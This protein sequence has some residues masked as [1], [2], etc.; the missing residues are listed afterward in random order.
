[1]TQVTQAEDCAAIEEGGKSDLEIAAYLHAK[2]HLVFSKVMSNNSIDLIRTKAEYMFIILKSMFCHSFTVCVSLVSPLSSKVTLK[3][4]S[5]FASF[6]LLM[7]LLNSEVGKV[8]LPTF[9][10]CIIISKYPSVHDLICLSSQGEWCWEVSQPPSTSRRGTPGSEI[11][12]NS[13]GTTIHTHN[14]TH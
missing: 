10:E 6:F 8:C 3:S 4:V 2:N 14:H 7:Q 9:L 1:M 13:R 11:P 12:A 5:E